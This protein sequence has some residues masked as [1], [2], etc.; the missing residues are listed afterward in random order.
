MSLVFIFYLAKY[1]IA[2]KTKTAIPWKRTLIRISLLLYFLLK[3]PFLA[4][5]I[6]PTT[7]INKASS[8]EA[9]KI[10]GKTLEEFMVNSYQII[11]KCLIIKY[12]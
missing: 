10:S 8:I 4:I 11:Y 9:A 12:F 6:T 3:F 5:A 1:T 2:A 7:T